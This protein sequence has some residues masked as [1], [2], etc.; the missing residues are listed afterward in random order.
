RSLLDLWRMRRAVAAWGEKLDVFYFPADY[1]YFPVSTPAR[2]IVTKH[3]MTDRRMPELLFPNWKSRLFWDAKIRLAMRRSD[4]IFT[5][6]ETS[7][8]DI[9]DAFRLPGECVRVVA[10][11]VDPSFVPAARGTE[12][13]AILAKYGIRDDERFVL[14]VGGISPHKNLET[15]ILAFE[16]WSRTNAKLDVSLILVG[17][18]AADVFH[19][20]FNALQGLIA[21]HSLGASVRFPGFVPDADLRHFYSA[22]DCLVLPSFYEGFGLPVL[23]AM[24]CGTAVIASNAGALPEVVADAGLLFDPHLP[25]EL[26]ECLGRVLSDESL[27]LELVERGKLRSRQFTWEASARVAIEAF[28]QLAR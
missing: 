28:E 16:R 6:S 20:S 8:R 5:V 21:T 12:R 17:D 10:D 23:E 27:R 13:T 1:T 19:S 15:L 4:M 2:V 24:A 9:I 11:A 26:A 14:Y 25:D 22:A 7:R 18:Y 3:D